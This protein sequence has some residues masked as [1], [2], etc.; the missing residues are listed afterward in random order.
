VKIRYGVHRFETQMR[1]N[2]SKL[3]RFFIVEHETSAKNR[4]R[5]LL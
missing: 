2:E 3:E 5:S 1:S 4:S